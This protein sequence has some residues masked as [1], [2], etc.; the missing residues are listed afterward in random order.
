LFVSFILVDPLSFELGELTESDGGRGSV[1]GEATGGREVTVAELW[2]VRVV[3]HGEL[4]SA[5]PMVELGFR[6]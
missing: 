1:G 6:F 5:A 2:V 3:A 4:L